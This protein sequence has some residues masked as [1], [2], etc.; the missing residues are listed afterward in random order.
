[1][2]YR[3]LC[4]GAQQPTQLPQT[5]SHQLPIRSIKASLN[6][7]LL[8]ASDN[9]TRQKKPKCWS[10]VV[11]AIASNWRARLEDFSLNTELLENCLFA[12]EYHR[13]ITGVISGWRCKPKLETVSHTRCIAAPRATQSSRRDG[14]ARGLSN[15]WAAHIS[16]GT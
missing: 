1:M 10:G 6:E 3:K 4:Q 9:P 16:A 12:C 14:A 7:R 13:K 5:P 11:P 2:A 8:G 15:T